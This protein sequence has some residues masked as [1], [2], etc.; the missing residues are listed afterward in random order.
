MVNKNI[1]RTEDEVRDS[2]KIL[3]GFD[4][5]EANVKQGTGQILLL[6]TFYTRYN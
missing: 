6:V 1:Y 2:A 5:V 3:L 4:K